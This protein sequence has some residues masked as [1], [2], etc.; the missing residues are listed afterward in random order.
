MAETVLGRVAR[1]YALTGFPE[2][3]ASCREASRVAAKRY[4]TACRRAARAVAVYDTRRK[5]A[6]F[7]AVLSKAAM[8]FRLLAV[9]VLYGLAGIAE[10]GKTVGHG[11]S[12]RLERVTAARKKV[13]HTRVNIALAFVAA[14]VLIFVASIYRIG[15]EVILDGESIGYVSSQSTVENSLSAVS[16]KAAEILGRPYAVSPNIRYRF[17]IVNKNQIYDSQGVEESLLNSISDIDR[18]CVMTVDGVPVAASRDPADLH[19]AREAILGTNSQKAFIQDVRIESQL[20]SVSLIRSTDELVR[21]LTRNVREEIR[22]T[23]ADAQTAEEIA[24][25]HGLSAGALQELNPGADLSALTVGQSLLVQRAKPYLSVVSTE[26]L[27]YEQ[28]VVYD[29]EYKDDPTLW[30]GMSQ[31]ITEGVDGKELVMATSTSVDGYEPTVQVNGSITLTEPVTEVIAVGSRTR[32]TTGTFIRPSK[33]RQSSAFGRRKIW[34][35]YSY[36]YGLDFEGRVGDSVVASDGGV[37]VYA[38]W[39]SAYGLCVIID[40]ENGYKT[41]YGHNSK[42]TVEVGQRVGQG[43]EIAKV[44]NTGRSTGPHVHFEIVVNGVQKNPANYLD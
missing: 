39:K 3:Q 1:P 40:H 43:E 26:P 12:F 37:V 2:K 41:V 33:G 38:S 15:L 13:N 32:D 14:G 10:G 8:P 29:T 5:L 25:A 4:G 44:G 11:K 35:S 23:V 36:H 34:G 31:L 22:V 6:V 27:S 18:L 24:A 42:I 16:A 21:N 30:A 28:P 20:A 17:S 19:A 7:L 9:S